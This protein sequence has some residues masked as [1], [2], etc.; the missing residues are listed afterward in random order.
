MAN[1]E[2]V[3]EGEDVDEFVR[4]QPMVG[5]M[6]TRKRDALKTIASTEDVCYRRRTS[7]RLSAI[8]TIRSRGIGFA[9]RSV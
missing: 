2:N 6:Q 9:S 4:R 1:A 7:G 8:A 5:A 3:G